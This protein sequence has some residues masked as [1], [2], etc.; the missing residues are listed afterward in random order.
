MTNAAMELIHMID[1][2]VATSEYPLAPPSSAS[3]MRIPVLFITPASVV[4][5]ER[6]PSISRPNCA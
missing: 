3:P 6:D 4:T 1:G 2:I 5:S